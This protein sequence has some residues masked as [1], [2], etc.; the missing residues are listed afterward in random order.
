MFM[1]LDVQT[2][3]L[4]IKE[5]RKELHLTQSDIKEKVGISSGNISDIEQGKRLP[6]ASTLVQ[7]SKVLECSIDYILTG[8]SPKSENLELSDLGESAQQLLMLFNKL[9]SDDQDELILIAQMKV[10][11]RKRNKEK[12]AN[13][14]NNNFVSETA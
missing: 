2:I 6:A 14:E 7:L 5:R 10:N 13:S 8:F 1:Q 12:L 11:K 4:R 3:G 9:S